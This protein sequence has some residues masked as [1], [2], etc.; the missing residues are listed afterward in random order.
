MENKRLGEK[1]MEDMEFDSDGNVI[2][3]VTVTF[4]VL[5]QPLPVP[6]WYYE[7]SY[8][9]M[10]GAMNAVRDLDAAG[11]PHRIVKREVIETAIE[12]PNTMC[13]C[14]ANRQPHYPEDHEIEIDWGRK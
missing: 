5:F 8:R 3:R 12:I 7:A 1:M 6:G 4:V 10:S 14:R 2:R 9:T 13:K 11:M